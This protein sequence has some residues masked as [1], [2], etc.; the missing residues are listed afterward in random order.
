MSLRDQGRGFGTKRTNLGRL[1]VAVKANAAVLPDVT[2]E[3]AEVETALGEADDAIRR[4][5]F[6]VAQGRQATKDVEA[7]LGRGLE[8]G[9]RLQNAVRFK[10]GFKDEMLAEFQ[11]KPRGKR[12]S[13]AVKKARESQQAN[14]ALQQENEALK[15]QLVKLADGSKD[16][17]KGDKET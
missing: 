6:H 4:K 17:S 5:D 9:I 8:A 2:A 14:V 1:L 7:A 13:P 10:L 3:T 16:E 15:E 12:P 11:L